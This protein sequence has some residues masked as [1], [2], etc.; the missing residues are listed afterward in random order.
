MTEND[1]AEHVE[2]LDEEQHEEVQEAT[3]EEYLAER[4]TQARQATRLLSGLIAQ[5][6]NCIDC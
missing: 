5:K 4:L 3:P 2:L 6:K 1:S